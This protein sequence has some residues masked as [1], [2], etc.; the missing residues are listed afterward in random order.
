[1]ST[2]MLHC[3][4]EPVTA[5][6]LATITPAS[7]AKANG[8]E[9]SPTYMPVDHTELVQTVRTEISSALGDQFSFR[10]ANYGVRKN[11]AELFALLSW[12][13]T[14]VDNPSIG[15]DVGIV[16]SLNYRIP[17]RFAGGVGLFICDN[18]ALSGDVLYARKHT[19]LVWDSI[20][21]KIG[22]LAEL[23]LGTYQETLGDIEKLSK[24]SLSGNR[25]YEVL[26]RLCGNKILT[27]RML[28][29][30]VKDWHTPRHEQF[31][32]RSMWSLYNCA[33]EAMKKHNPNRIVEAHKMLHSE[34]VG[35]V[36]VDSNHPRHGWQGANNQLKS[37]HPELADVIPAIA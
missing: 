29:A 8:T 35:C 20:M 1:M 18:M 32:P 21:G 11:G 31:E 23:A 4:G 2:L 27:P 33:N 10:S 9:Y 16:N 7:V 25:A 22:Q 3:G 19:K 30:A 28:T 17:V 6:E 37:M 24:C 15:Y 36:P 13:P 5:E 12:K 14:V 34:M 26:G